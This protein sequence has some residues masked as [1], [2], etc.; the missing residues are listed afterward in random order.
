[1]LEYQG[2]I[3][4]N[5]DHIT[6]VLMSETG[7]SRTDASLEAP[8]V[9]DGINHWAGKAEAFLADRHPKAHSVLF[10]T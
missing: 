1:M 4:D 2:W 10:K 3:L 6:D 8:A 7:K 9:A 5:A